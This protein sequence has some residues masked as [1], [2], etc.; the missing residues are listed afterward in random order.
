MVGPRRWL[1]VTPCLGDLDQ[2]AAGVVEH[3]PRHATHAAD[4]QLDPLSTRCSP[5][6]ACTAGA[7]TAFE[8]IS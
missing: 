5:R 3:R 1:L 8:Q 2:V 7:S 6:W 4:L